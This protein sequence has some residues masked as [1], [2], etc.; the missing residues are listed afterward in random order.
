MEWK[1]LDETVIDTL[2]KIGCGDDITDKVNWSLDLD[3]DHFMTGSLHPVMDNYVWKVG[4]FYRDD[5]KIVPLARYDTSLCSSKPYRD[6]LVYTLLNLGVNP[7]EFNQSLD[8]LYSQFG[9]Q[10]PDSVEGIRSFMSGIMDQLRSALPNEY[11][12]TLPVLREGVKA[13]IQSLIGYLGEDNIAELVKAKAPQI[14]DVSNPE[15]VQIVID[16]TLND[17]MGAHKAA[18]V[19]VDKSIFDQGWYMRNQLK[20]TSGEN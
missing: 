4:I 2:S 18:Y 5:E 1:P 10:F 6:L 11:L 20:S 7:N 12:C 17:I 16:T 19:A 9:D 3:K 15:V 14:R 8:S 13:A